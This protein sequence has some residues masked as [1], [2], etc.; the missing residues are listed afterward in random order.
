MKKLNI[1]DDVEAVLKIYSWRLLSSVKFIILFPKQAPSSAAVPL[2]HEYN[3]NRQAQGETCVRY[4]MGSEG[5]NQSDCS[6]T[7]VFA[8][9][10]AMPAACLRK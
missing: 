8:A 3:I 1:T 9:P 6:S 4:S 7:P 5:K 10:F 2:R